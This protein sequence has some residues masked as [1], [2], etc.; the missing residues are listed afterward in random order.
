M[1][2]LITVVTALAAAYGLLWHD[3]PAETSRTHSARPQPE[4]S[5]GTTPAREERTA[6]RRPFSHLL[7]NAIGAEAERRP[8]KKQKIL[9]EPIHQF[10]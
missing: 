2:T 6:E 1:I 9:H 8:I 10:R 7:V 5:E 3:L 4:K